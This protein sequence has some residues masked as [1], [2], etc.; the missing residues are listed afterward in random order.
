MDTPG[1]WRVQ[2]GM[3]VGKS[4]GIPYNDFLRTK[5]EYTDFVLRVSFRLLNH[6]G[7]SGVQFRSRSVPDSHEVVGYQADIAPRYCIACL[8][9]ESRRRRFLAKVTP[10]S[11]LL[12]RKNTWN[13]LEITA[14]GNRVTILLNGVQ[15][16]DFREKV[17]DIA[18]SGFIALQIHSGPA[19]EIHFKNL[20][21]KTNL[22]TY[23]NPPD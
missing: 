3:I 20:L 16:V 7:N 17:S 1:L 18:R 4:P 12:V 19:M 8:Y 22:E 11:V 10:E 15:T 2:E 13:D 6:S 14:R 5:E 9:D 23:S 21:I